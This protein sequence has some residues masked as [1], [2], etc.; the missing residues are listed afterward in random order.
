[1]QGKGGVGKVPVASKKKEKAVSSKVSERPR[2]FG[3][4][5][6]ATNDRFTKTGSGQT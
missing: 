4:T 1:M 3:L 2:F 6:Y 5:F